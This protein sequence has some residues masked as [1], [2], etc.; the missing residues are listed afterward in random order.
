MY[1]VI[2]E[3]KGFFK[4][5]KE[6]IKYIVSARKFAEMQKDGLINSNKPASVKT[7]AK[8]PILEDLTPSEEPAKT[9]PEDLTSL[10]KDDLVE[11]AK[12]LGFEGEVT[13]AT[14][15]ASLI[16]FINSKQV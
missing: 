16:E 12:R 14:T 13:I 8:A 11:I 15:K 6:K 7:K 9:A 2:S 10:K 5:E 1:S 4:L 3:G